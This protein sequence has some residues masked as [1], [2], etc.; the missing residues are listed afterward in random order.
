MS[1]INWIEG[2]AL[3]RD[4]AIILH[5]QEERG[6]FFNI[7]KAK[8]LLADLERLKNEK[9]LEIRPYLSW[10]I[11]NLEKKQKDSD[12]FS[13]VKKIRLLK[14]DYTE[15]VL[16]HYPEETDIVQGPF[17]RIRI[18]EPSISKRQLI[19]NQLLNLGWK[20]KVFT[21]KGQPQLTI[22]GKPVD[23]L[24]SV[25]PFGR[26]LADWYTYNHRQSQIAGFIEN[27]RPD[28]RIS[29]VM[30]GLTNTFRHKHKIVANV[31]RPT[32]IYGKEM[33]SLFTVPEGKKFVG[34]DVSGLELRMLAHW[35]N[36]DEYIHILL[37]DDIHVFNQHKAGLPTR[38]S[39][40]N[41]IYAFL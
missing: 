18:E 1:K 14:G 12:E 29:S 20:P 5:E 10:D 8:F 28:N 25:G 19:I 22:K 38:D 17:S 3:E 16:K 4:V 32:S 6:I 9:Y 31:P 11:Q 21:E 27:V 36:D 15:S 30:N 35:M 13:Y 2:L 33:R 40:K 24:L 37:N 41:F 26:A 7:G 39:A 34:A 23:T